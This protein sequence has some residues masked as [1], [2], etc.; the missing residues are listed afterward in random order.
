MTSCNQRNPLRYP[1]P[2]PIC[3]IYIATHQG[4]RSNYPR[5]LPPFHP[6]QGY[7]LPP[8]WRRA[9]RVLHI[10]LCEGLG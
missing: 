6:T 7:P 9:G 1:H 4:K 2:C 10:T 8:F 3:G 5:K